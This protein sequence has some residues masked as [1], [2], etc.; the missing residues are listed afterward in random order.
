MYGDMVYAIGGG[1]MPSDAAYYGF[2]N[3]GRFYMGG[4]E[5]R[6]LDL[7]FILDETDVNCVPILM[8]GEFR[9]WDENWQGFLDTALDF[10][11]Y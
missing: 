7:Y 9:A 2:R 3:G 5:N 4:V 6:F 11:S 1:D 10:K 8:T